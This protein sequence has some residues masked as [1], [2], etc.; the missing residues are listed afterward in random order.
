[1]T[2]KTYGTDSRL[3]QQRAKLHA[4]WRAHPEATGEAVAVALGV[5]PYTAL[6][7]RPHGLPRTERDLKRIRPMPANAEALRLY[8][9]DYPLAEIAERTGRS[10]TTTRRYLRSVI[11]ARG[12]PS[13]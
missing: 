6:A 1:M 8:E 10:I 13:A 7:N 9:L 3:R 11:K 12:T 4:Y 2:V 5:S